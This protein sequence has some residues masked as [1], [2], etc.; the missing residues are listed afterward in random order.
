MRSLFLL[1]FIFI[2]NKAQSQDVQ[3]AS[4]LLGFSSEFEYKKDP[5]QY[6]AKLVLGKPSVTPSNM[7]DKTSPC[8]WAP[9]TENNE[10][11]E[12]I[13]VG[14]KTP[15]Q[16]AQVAIVELY[17]THVISKMWLYDT[18]NKEHLIYMNVEDQPI[19]NQ[20][21][22]LYHFFM[23]A[24]DYKA[25]ALKIELQTSWLKG[26]SQIDAIAISSNQD[27]IKIEPNLVE[28]IDT[29]IQV[30]AVTEINSDA[31][32]LAPMLAPD[33]KRLYFTR[34]KHPENLGNKDKQDIWYAD[35]DK[36][37]KISSPQ[38]IGEP[39]NN[40]HNNSITS[41][42]PDNQTAL[43]L[44]VYNKDG[45]ADKGISITQ[46]DGDKWGFPQEVKIKDYYNKSPYGE[47]FL[48]ADGNTLV[49]AVMR[50]EGEGNKDI[51][52]SFWEESEQ[53][54]S[55]PKNIGSTVNTAASEISPFLAADGKTMYFSTSGHLGYGSSDIFVTH[56]LDDTWTNWSE[57]QNLGPIINTPRF[58]AYYTI[59]A[60]GDYAYFTRYNEANNSDIFR[61]RLS[62]T[63]Q[64]NPVSLVYGKVINAKTNQPIGANIL[65]ESFN[66]HKT[67]GKASANSITGEYKIALPMGDAY[68][69][70]AEANG[71]IAVNQNLDLTALDKYTEVEMDIKM[72][73]IE[74]GQIIRLNNV[75][76]D[77]DKYSLKKAGELELNRLAKLLIQQSKM[78][79]QI[80]GHTD[81][82][83]SE[84]YNQKLSENRAN[85][86][87]KYLIEQGVSPKRLDYKGFGEQKP[88]TENDTEEGRAENRRVEFEILS[89]E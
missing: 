51:H 41:I 26:Y 45:T 79:I 49:M 33:G 62:K 27:S 85:T 14:F 88:I 7:I 21:S 44:N 6:R 12:W 63:Q 30:E 81:N 47:Y 74:K 48:T 57:P 61:I 16:V 11:P 22:Q 67:L 56:R 64:P 8:A 82:K 87:Y 5:K 68:G 38:N 9:A 65:Y 76:F 72:F 80:A 66:L 69:F 84:S 42:T 17:R 13:K 36:E 35:I 32:D 40:E 70:L 73:P 77:T 29:T 24:T 58:D 53:V 89:V 50:D 1:I 46:K 23:P 39:L 54:W 86:V 55:V 59:A 19:S 75:F 28:N 43:I 25:K 78:K 60:A 3:W 71:F 18:E 31:D 37:N 83:G 15:I 20:N 4:E 52:V 34:Q 2:A 10:N